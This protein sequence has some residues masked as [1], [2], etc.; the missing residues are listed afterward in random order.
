MCCDQLQARLSRVQTLATNGEGTSDSR[1]SFHDD[2]SDSDAEVGGD[3]PQQYV[4]PQSNMSL[5]DQH[6][7]LKLEALGELFSIGGRSSNIHS[8]SSVVNGANSTEL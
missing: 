3:K 1:D 5:L 6:S 2:D 8:L 7:K 4:G